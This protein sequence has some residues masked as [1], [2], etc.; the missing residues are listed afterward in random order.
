MNIFLRDG[1]LT[2]SWLVNAY[3]LEIVRCIPHDKIT[4]RRIN[5][6]MREAHGTSTI[7]AALRR[8]W[9]DERRGLVDP[10]GLEY[11]L[12]LEGYIHAN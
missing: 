9:R 10:E 11:A 2:F 8:L 3:E 5:R 6:I 4:R 7:D 12:A 1:Y